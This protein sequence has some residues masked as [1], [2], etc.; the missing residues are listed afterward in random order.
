M[1]RARLF[2]LPLLAALA[3]PALGEDHHRGHDPR[4][5]DW[6]SEFDDLGQQDYR[7]LPLKR[8]AQIVAERF[9][10]RLIAAR[11]VP[12]RPEERARGV[13]LVHQL[14]LLT[15]ARDVLA[16]RLDAR[17]G[18]FLEVAGAGLT[19]ARRKGNAR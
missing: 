5:E 9:R 8:A 19:E 1:I 13:V 12:P 10:G 17:S 15:P 4:A 7:V 16:I 11:L 14:R 2:A 3:L 6:A 18:A